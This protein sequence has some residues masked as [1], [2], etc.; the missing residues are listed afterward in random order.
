MIA[1]LVIVAVLGG[2]GIWLVW[3]VPP[4][5][6]IPTPDRVVTPSSIPEPTTTGP[7]NFTA[8][9]QSLLKILPGGFNATNCTSDRK[10]EDAI[11][12]AVLTCGPN[13][14]PGGP[15]SATFY[16]YAEASR[17]NSDF[18]AYLQKNPANACPNGTMPGRYTTDGKDSG[19]MACYKDSD[20][21]AAMVYTYEPQ[22]AA[23][24]VHGS[25]TVTAA[26][27]FDWWK[28]QGG[29]G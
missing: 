29:F 2:L 26:Q 14:S 6:P 22:P 4:P 24:I 21:N 17:L 1:A 19:S 18:T 5:P 3:P 16:A 7:A 23:A 25:P 27:M 28:Q 10:D 8:T 11:T 15:V 13:L 12:P 20:G 9:E